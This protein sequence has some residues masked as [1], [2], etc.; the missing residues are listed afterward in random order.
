MGLPI[1]VSLTGG[2]DRKMKTY[3]NAYVIINGQ[4]LTQETSVT[5]EKKSNSRPITTLHNGFAG[6]GKGAG[7]IE[8][9]VDNAIPTA[10]IE[11]QVDFFIKEGDSIEVGVVLGSRQTIAKGFITDATYSH[12]TNDHAKLSFRATC[13]LENFE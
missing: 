8:I 5:L 10:D 1:G 4:I 9:T 11:F 7:V 12:S 2:D 6:F 13:R 3:T